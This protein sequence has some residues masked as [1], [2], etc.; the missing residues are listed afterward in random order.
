MTLEEPTKSFIKVTLENY[1]IIEGN[2]LNNKLQKLFNEFRDNT[3]KY[4]VLIKVAALNKIYSTAITNI[5]PVVDQINKI[6]TVEVNLKSLDSYIS[7]VDKISKIKWTNGR[8]NTFSRNNLSFASK[9]VHFISDRQ[10]PI[11]DSYIWIIIKGYLG[12]K[13]RNKISF[14]NPIDYQEFYKTFCE[15]KRMFDLEKY[16]NYDIDKFLWTYGRTLINKISNELHLDL[17]Q[18][19]SELKRRIKTT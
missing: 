16:S 9:Y 13:N 12:Q 5:T 2:E 1:E 18:A 10:I 19:K 6:A 3:N 8:N 11:Y 14:G 7:F 4:D 15:F 17:N